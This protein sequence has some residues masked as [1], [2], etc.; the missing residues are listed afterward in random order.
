MIGVFDSGSGG[1]TVLRAIRERMPSSDFVYF[2]D[3]KNAPYGTK[4]Q[5]ELSALTFANFHRLVETGATSI[6]SACN[7]ASTALAVSLLDTENISPDRVIEMVGPTVRALKHTDSSILL[8]ATPATIESGAYQNAFS[9]IGKE[10]KTLAFADL[11]RAIEFGA[12][13]EEIEKS[14]RTSLESI[15]KDSFR[16][17]VLACTHY[18]LVLSVFKR[19]LGDEVLIFDPADAVAERV[20][21][22]WWPRE[23]GNGNLKF[24]ISKDS[25]PFRGFVKELFPKDADK[26]EVLE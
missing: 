26:I 23:A 11:G 1:L 12:P 8:A 17:L 22:E 6:V 9:M 20:E 16:I 2:G 3:I 24:L 25:A 13:E 15:P 14:I 10:I 21:K 4:T 18:P 7:S 19:V 5:S